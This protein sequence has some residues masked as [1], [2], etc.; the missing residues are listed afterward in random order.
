MSDLTLL[1]L[2]FHSDGDVQIGPRSL[3][4]GDDEQEPEPARTDGGEP[5][6]RSVPLPLVGAALAGVA[7]AAAAAWRAL[8]AE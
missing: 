5:E 3:G 7:L 4:P 8:G 2:H 1:E 6:G